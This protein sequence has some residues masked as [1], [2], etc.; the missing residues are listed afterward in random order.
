MVAYDFFSRRANNSSIDS[1]KSLDDFM[2]SPHF[3]VD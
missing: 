3:T 1:L 2:A